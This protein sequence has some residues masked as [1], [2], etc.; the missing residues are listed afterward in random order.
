MSAANGHHTWL[1]SISAFIETLIAVVVKVQ[2][3]YTRASF[4]AM[5]VLWTPD[6]VRRAG[7]LLYQSSWLL[8]FVEPVAVLEV[9]DKRRAGVFVGRGAGERAQHGEIRCRVTRLFVFV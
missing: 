9:V 5:G 7:W 3:F 2:E 6:V 1:C 8:S 4:P